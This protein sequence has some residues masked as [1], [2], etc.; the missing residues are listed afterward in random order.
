MTPPTKEQ[1][2]SMYET[3]RTIRSFEEEILKR[4]ENGLAI[5]SC[6]GH[7]AVAVGIITQL[8][9]SDLIVS[10]HRPWGHF[11]AK[12]GELGESFAEILGKPQG[13]CK[14][15][16]GEMGICKPGIG[17]VQSTMIVGASM[18]L[19]CGVALSIKMDAIKQSRFPAGERSIAAVFF[20]EGATTNG[21]FNEAMI[22]AKLYRL[23]LLFVCENNG[24]SG[25]TPSAE[26]L[27][28]ELVTHRASGYGFPTS[29]CDGSDVLAVWEAAQKAI[30]YVRKEEKPYFLECLV[31]RINRHKVPRM[32]DARSPE[33]KQI[34]RMRDPLPKLKNALLSEGILTPENDALISQR[35]I[36]NLEKA[37]EFAHS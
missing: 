13:V 17:F 22:M 10:N 18:T 6:A 33:V 31:A 20:G 30:E 21:A 23:P 2:R 9:Q 19:A 32:T 15:T 16:G 27:P 25:N 34:A 1:M 28:T 35:I 14:G 12:G 29:V 24:L 5:H 36:Q 7:E 37:I 8:D 11:L 4:E 3:M 26:Y